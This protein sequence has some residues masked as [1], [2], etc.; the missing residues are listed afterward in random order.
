MHILSAATMLRCH[1]AIA[2]LREPRIQA[3]V[4]CSRI[5][6]GCQATA[7]F[8]VNRSAV[9]QA[10]FAR[11][12]AVRRGGETGFLGIVRRDGMNVREVPLPRG[13]AFY[14]ATYEI[15]DIDPSRSDEFDVSDAEAGARHMVEG[16]VFAQMEHPVT[17]A[18]ALES[19]DG[20]AI[21]AHTAPTG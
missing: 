15:D 7:I 11:R 20:F 21:A 16:G 8:P 19:G 17:S 18:C 12:S 5:A 9:L 2:R 3:S 1:R 6:S 10:R 4:A 14:V 13:R